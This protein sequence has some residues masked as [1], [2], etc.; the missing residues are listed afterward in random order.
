[1]RPVTVVEFETA[2]YVAAAELEAIHDSIDS[3]VA[4][5]PVQLYRTLLG[6]QVRDALARAASELRRLAD[7]AHRNHHRWPTPAPTPEKP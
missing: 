1:M 4:R 7:E 5:T 3:L 6:V 2:A